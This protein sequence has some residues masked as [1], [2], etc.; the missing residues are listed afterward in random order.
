[1]EDPAGK[2]VPQDDPALPQAITATHT[3]PEAQT[4]TD[5][6]SSVA[7]SER[8]VIDSSLA[9]ELESLSSG[10]EPEDQ[11]YEASEEPSV[12]AEQVE[13]ASEAVGTDWN[14]E[15]GKGMPKGV[16]QKS[17][18]G[19]ASTVE[20]HDGSGMSKVGEDDLSSKCEQQHS[21]GSVDKEFV[22]V[23]YPSMTSDHSDP[24]K[25]PQVDQKTTSAMSPQDSVQQVTATSS[26]AT[27]TRPIGGSGDTTPILVEGDQT[28]Q[29][30]DGN[31]SSILPIRVEITGSSAQPENAESA[32]RLADDSQEVTGNLEGEDEG[33]Q[34]EIEGEL[35]GGSEVAT[36]RKS[37]DAEG[38]KGQVSARTFESLGLLYASSPNVKHNRY[39]QNH[40]FMHLHRTYIVHGVYL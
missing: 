20:E 15:T 24:T 14:E 23:N 32:Q 31:E 36:E 29:L 13:R 2:E 22:M 7:T 30:E 35:S 18:E 1:M 17:D 5:P 26:Q 19:L 10:S 27:D 8:G 37:S 11:F 6:G 25:Q 34:V 39:S 12:A 28:V 38:E 21:V 3:P 16:K 40:I 4:T 33:G 9:P